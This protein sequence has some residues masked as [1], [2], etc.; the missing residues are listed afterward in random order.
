MSEENEA[1]ETAAQESKEPVK[2]EDKIYS[3]DTKVPPAPA[4]AAVEDEAKKDEAPAAEETP[5]SD[6]GDKEDEKPEEKKPEDEK[7]EGDKSEDK[8]QEEIKLKNIEDSVLTDSQVDEIA[9][10]AKKQGLSQEQAESLLERENALRASI[11]DE[12][13]NTFHKMADT[14]VGQ[15]KKDPEVGGEEFER[16]AEVGKRFV[17]RFFDQEVIKTLD[18]TGLGNHPGLVRGFVRAGRLMEMDRMVRAQKEVSKPKSYAE[19]IY[20][21]QNKQ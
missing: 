11:V 1:T 19:R 14:W 17:R 4:P 13:Q 3:E 16:N 8:K 2:L 6:E 10:Y 18:E 20:P 7:A 5:A 9:E 12:Y 15:L 21:S